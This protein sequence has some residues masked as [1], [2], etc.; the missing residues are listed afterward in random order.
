MLKKGTKY[1]PSRTPEKES[2]NINDNIS[3][4]NN[5]TKVNKIIENKLEEFYNG[6]INPKSDYYDNS[7][8]IEKINC[9]SNRKTFMV[10]YMF[11]YEENVETNDISRGYKTVYQA[12]IEDDSWSADSVEQAILYAY[13]HFGKSYEF[14]KIWR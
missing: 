14:K 2:N 4:N 10:R 13:R 1:I 5:N 8:R 11:T 12:A 3:D 7:Y 6:N 9:S